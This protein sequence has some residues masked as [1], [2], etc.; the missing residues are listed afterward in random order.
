ML[1]HTCLKSVNIITFFNGSLRISK[2]EEVSC[3]YNTLKEEA[4]WAFNILSL[5]MFPLVL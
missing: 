4:F 5:K 1:V 2:N 3:K